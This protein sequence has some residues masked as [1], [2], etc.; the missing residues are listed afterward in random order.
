M[1]GGRVQG[2]GLDSEFFLNPK[3]DTQKKRHAE[4]DLKKWCL[5]KDGMLCYPVIHEIWLERKGGEYLTVSAFFFGQN[6][7][8]EKE[9]YDG[10]KYIQNY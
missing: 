4:I 2:A 8:I 1:S 9:S 5:A 7:L 10:W 6:L 3:N